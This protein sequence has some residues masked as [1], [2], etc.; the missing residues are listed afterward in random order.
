MT[1]VKEIGEW[2]PFEDSI[3]TYRRSLRK[4]LENLKTASEE[5]TDEIDRLSFR[6]D[7]LEQ[8]V[9]AML[10]A[11]GLYAK[12]EDE[13]DPYVEGRHKMSLQARPDRSKK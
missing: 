8:I 4:K 2:G 3:S 10:N 13:H 12:H 11:Q 5:V 1:K 7:K 9:Y 6:I